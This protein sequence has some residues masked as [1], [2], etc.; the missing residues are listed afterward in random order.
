METNTN[1]KSASKPERAKVPKLKTTMRRLDSATAK[2]L[3]QLAE[4]ANKKDFGRKVRD[5]DILAMAVTLVEDEHLKELQEQSFTEKDHLS[6]AHQEYQK[7]HGK[8]SLDQFIGKL[9]KGE[10]SPSKQ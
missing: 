2:A 9:L 6:M 10:I 8:I 3:S 4:R 5:S 7:R 1:E